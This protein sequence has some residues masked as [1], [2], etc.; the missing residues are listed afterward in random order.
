MRA[1]D[2]I[3]KKRGNANQK[4]QELSKDEI[5]FLVNGYVDG[6]IP[7]YQMSA[8]LMAV[9]FNGMTFE[10]TGVLTNCMLHSGDVIDL[11][12]LTNLKGPF[13]DKHSTGGVGDKISL[14]LAPI[15][16][17]LGVS[18]PMMSG[19]GLGHTGGTLDKLESIEGYNVNLS[20]KEFSSIIENHGFAMMGQTQSIVPA[21]RKMYALRDVTGTVESIPLITG[22]IL[23]KKVAEGSDALV[24]DVKCGLGAFMKTESDAESLATFLVKTSQAMGKSACALLTN[25]D[26]PLGYKTGNYLEIEE[27]LE[28][29]Q[30]KGPSDIMELTFELGARMAVFGKVADSVQDGIKK[31][32]DV[33]QSGKALE[34]FL[35]NVRAQGGNP[36]K[37]LSEQGKRRSKYESEIF[38]E[39]DGYLSID[40][41]K[42]G[43]A[44]IN[45]GVGRNKTSDKVDADSGIIF[46]KKQGDFVHK[47]EKIMSIYGKNEQALQ[48]GKISMQKAITT[49]ENQIVQKKLILKEIK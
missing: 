23:S 49:S 25:M 44:C 14:P 36:D 2:I 15:V 45:L 46:C 7:D 11:R 24:F 41:Y 29:L 38:A 39:Q 28:C 9:Y 26:S 43:I 42:T 33:V 47:G 21:D 1:A 30:G 32:K 20:E 48:E 40:A 16:A 35:E 22:S 4:G 31:C 27:T 18:I 13:V 3:I 34:K 5:E 17:S 10:E 8:F 12:K 6:S 37:L 19:R